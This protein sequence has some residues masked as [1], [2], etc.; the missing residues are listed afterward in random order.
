[1][2]NYSAQITPKIAEYL[3][4]TFSP[5]DA[6]LEEIVERSKAR[7][8]PAIQVGPMDGLHLE[9]LTRIS[10]A[11]KAVEIG[12]LGGYSGVC[13]AR[14]MGPQGI[15]YTFDADRKHTEVAIE[16]FRRA[17]VAEQVKTF[18]GP[19]S[20]NLPKINNDGPFDL[21]FVDADKTG[22]PDYLQWAAENLRIGG[23][24]IGDNTLGWGMIADQK[25]EDAED[26]AAIRA[27]QKFNQNAGAQNSRF[28]ATLLPTGEGLTVAVKVK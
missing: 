9:I 2:K 15:L 21:V 25:F 11:K 13:I 6:I 18:I 12:T 26:E 23:L 3:D 20:Q 16:S 1:M 5:Q 24:L 27:L 22:Y 4:Q 19:A 28:R 14:G 7:G 10:G 8:L 17:G